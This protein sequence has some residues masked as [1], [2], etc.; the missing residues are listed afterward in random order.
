MDDVLDGSWYSST[1][2]A[3]KIGKNSCQF[4]IPIIIYMDKTG[5]DA[6]QRH[7]L[8]PVLLHLVCSPENY[9]IRLELGDYWGSS[10]IY[11]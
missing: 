6:N 8:E 4:L 9:A 5:T 10:L 2:A 11:S 7:S 3:L 1:V